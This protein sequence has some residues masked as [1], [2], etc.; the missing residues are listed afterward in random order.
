MKPFHCPDYLAPAAARSPWPRKIEPLHVKNRRAAD[1]AGNIDRVADEFTLAKARR[2]FGDVINETEFA[3]TWAEALVKAF[4]HNPNPDIAR[5]NAFI[6]DHALPAL[7]RLNLTSKKLARR[8]ETGKPA[9][10]AFQRFAEAATAWEALLP[11]FRRQSAM[12]DFARA[13]AAGSA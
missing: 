10:K 9:L 6:R 5:A 8:I 13:D 1:T 12:L 3:R 11:E 7:C 2:D 4:A